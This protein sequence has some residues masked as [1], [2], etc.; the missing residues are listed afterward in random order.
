[1]ANL[2]PEEGTRFEDPELVTTQVREYSKLKE[3]ID[4][5]ETRQA[6]LR[7]KLFA[8]LDGEGEPDDK[9]NIF[10][11]LDSA[12]N[13]VVRIEKQRRVTR[14]LDELT[15]EQVIET[16][17]LGDEVYKTVR[18]LDED[19]LMAAHYEGKISEEDIELMFPAKVVWAL[20]LAKK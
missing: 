1:M 20:R 9:G 10:I 11:E 19:A 6:E 18:V 7:E 4:F 12:I 16:L 13:D 3:S 8:H 14:K 15:A 2:I 17:G 5:L